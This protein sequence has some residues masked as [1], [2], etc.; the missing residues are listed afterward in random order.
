MKNAKLKK[1]NRSMRKKIASIIGLLSIS[2]LMISCFGSDY[3]T[4]TVSASQTQDSTRAIYSTPQYEVDE[5]IVKE[6]VQNDAE[7]TVTP[8]TF[9]LCMDQITLFNPIDPNNMEK[10]A[11]ESFDLLE[12]DKFKSGWI[13]PKRYNMLTSKGIASLVIPLAIMR[14]DWHGMLITMRAGGNESTNGMWAGSIV[15]VNKSDLT[16][17]G[18]DINKI[19][20]SMD[21]EMVEPFRV[22]YSEECVWFSFGDLF[23]F[24]SD[25]DDYTKA[26][27]NYLFVDSA[28]TVSFIN[29]EAKDGTWVFGPRLTHGNEYCVVMPMSTIRLTD[30]V[31]PEIVISLDTENLIEFHQDDEGYYYACLSKNNPLPFRV[32]VDEYDPSVYLYTEQA[33]VDIHDA[34]PFDCFD[35]AVTV[36]D[37]GE[38]LHVLM[39]TK[40]NYAGLD[41]VEIFR[42]ASD[43]FD[44]NAK[45]IYA[46]TSLSIT[47]YEPAK[48]EEVY[49]FIRS[50]NLLGERSETKLM[51]QFSVEFTPF[52]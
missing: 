21:P 35:Y 7:F 47:D 29:G 36:T 49:Y 51:K 26:P 44:E 15:G 20:N 16:A 14:R 10:G 18:V 41:F 12:L 27:S 30:M 3:S 31:L 24:G 33:I 4:I 45:L 1:Y 25:T 42:S 17:H 38:F 2:I 5:S 39:Y 23:P 19:R 22:K 6:K 32:Y 11:Y 52:H 40:A 34:A 13:V 48:D 8:S 28:E 37:S 43:V 9:I 50:V 46:G